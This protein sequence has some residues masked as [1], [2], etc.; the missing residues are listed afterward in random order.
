MVIDEERRRRDAEAALG[1]F[2][3][4]VIEVERLLHEA[5]SATA[6]ATEATEVVEADLVAAR[7]RNDE[8]A[9]QLSQARAELAEER[10]YRYDAQAALTSLL[11]TKT[12][13]LA[14]I[15]RK[16]YS[17]LRGERGA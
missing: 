4:R 13:R 16:L 11:N 2:Y 14:R 9:A 10:R 15:P 12:M 5:R 1:D 8:L 17:M 6:D 3:H 7:A